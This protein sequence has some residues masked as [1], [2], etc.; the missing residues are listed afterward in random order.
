PANNGGSTI[1]G[2]TVTSIPAGGVDLNAG[3]TSLTHS[4]SGLTNG[5]SY[6][7]NV[8]AT[9]SAGTSIFSS[10]SNAVIPNASI[11]I[12]YLKDGLIETSLSEVINKE[13]VRIDIFPNPSKGRI[14]IRFSSQPNIGGRIDILDVS[15]RK[16]ASRI[17]TGISEE[18]NLDH[19]APGLY[20]VKSFLGSDLIIQKLIITK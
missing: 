3:S 6:T 12:S 20:L 17:I 2:Y 13:P 7:F 16:V 14:S 5:T 9:N 4:I 11:N 15:G 10:L 19:E 18:F 1:T 8:K